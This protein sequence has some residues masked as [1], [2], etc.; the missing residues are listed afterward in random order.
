[1]GNMLPFSFIVNRE[2]GGEVVKRRVMRLKGGS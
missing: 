2:M 1:M